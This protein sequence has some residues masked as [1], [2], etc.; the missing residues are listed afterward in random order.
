MGFSR[1]SIVGLLMGA[2]SALLAGCAGVAGSD[3]LRRRS[4]RTGDGYGSSSYG[5]PYGAPS[6]YGSTYGDAEWRTSSHG[7]GGEVYGSHDGQESDYGSQWKW[8]VVP[9]EK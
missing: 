5:D 3:E 9:D 8:F 7:V 1:R 4:R 2:G 6:S